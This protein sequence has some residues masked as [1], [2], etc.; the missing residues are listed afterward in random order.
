MF[1]VI[2]A[3]K[4]IPPDILGARINDARTLV[5]N[6]A[7]PGTETNPP[8]L[9]GARALASLASARKEGIEIAPDLLDSLTALAENA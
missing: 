3:A 4:L 7:V 1:I 9:P 5:R 8:R 2:D 6:S